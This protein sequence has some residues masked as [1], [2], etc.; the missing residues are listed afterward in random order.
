MFSE[1]NDSVSQMISLPVAAFVSSAYERLLGRSPSV[2]E[3][4]SNTGALRCGLG[5]I[6]L[7]ENIYKSDEFQTRL[8][9]TLT[10]GNDEFF[11]SRMFT[12]YLSR[13]PDPQGLQHYLDLL[14]SGSSREVV[15]H[16]IANSIEAR[17]SYSF[18]Y[19][20][21]RLLN[22]RRN[23]LHPFKRWFGKRR[24]LDRQ[25]NMDFEINQNSI[26]MSMLEI[27]STSLKSFEHKNVSGLENNKKYSAEVAKS[28]SLFSSGQVG[29]NRGAGKVLS[30][31][32]HAS[33]FLDRTNS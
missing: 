22:D 33:A 4:R 25:R 28:S 10:E 31:L 16:D 18:W 17:N 13:K 2:E 30:R 29:L 21:I 19:E 20:L 15:R 27:Q 8:Q 7:L 1:E 6:S 14:S 24:R 12:M 32:Q 9:D 11:V 3:L 26:R 23:S 5:R